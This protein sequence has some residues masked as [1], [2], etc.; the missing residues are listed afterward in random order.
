M[1]GIDPLLTVTRNNKQTGEQCSGCSSPSH[2]KVDAAALAS[3]SAPH[4]LRR[5]RCYGLP[6]HVLAM[7]R[8]S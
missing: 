2:A 6:R 5:P 4:L 1:S 8:V 3:K 7:H